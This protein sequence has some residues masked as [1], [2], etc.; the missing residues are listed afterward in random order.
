[1]EKM[2]KE[3]FLIGLLNFV[4]LQKLNIKKIKYILKYTFNCLYIFKLFIVCIKNKNNNMLL[5]LNKISL[6]DFTISVF[7][8]NVFIN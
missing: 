2:L 1:M 8:L 4:I 7:A 6:F 5:F 3:V